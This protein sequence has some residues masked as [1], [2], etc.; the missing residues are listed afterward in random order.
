MTDLLFPALHRVGNNLSLFFRHRVA[1]AVGLIFAADSMLFGTWVTHIPFVKTRL[2]LN[3]AELG[4]ALF[5]M[6]LGLLVMNPLS[7]R[8]L[9]RIG[10]VETTVYT[11]ILLIL[12]FSLPV[13]MPDRWSLMAAL[14]LVGL[15]GALL[16]V[17][18]NT[19][20]TH[21]EQAEGIFIMSSCHGMW[22][23]GGMLGSGLSAGMIALS[24]SP[25]THLIGL[26]VSLV[27][28]VW[29]VVRP[30][31][32]RVP[33]DEDQQGGSTFV[34]PNR[35]LLLM[36]FIGLSISLAEGVAFDW[37]TVYMR[38]VLGA[39]EQVAALA[40]TFFA[41][42]MMGTRFTGDVLIP[43][44][45][46]RLLLIVSTLVAILAL[47]LLILAGGPLLGVVGFLLLG[48]GVALGAPILYNAAARIP[49][50]APGAGLA[51]YATFS[52]VGFLAGPP[53][54]GLIGEYFGLWVGFACVAGL[55]GFSVVALRVVRL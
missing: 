35:D 33:V 46:E 29:I 51:T 13:W 36:I 25:Y 30:V 49:G 17:A 14:F 11:T 12:A 22:S 21:I 2:G 41:M 32:G 50:L 47:L 28:F 16:N 55:L 1:L 53:V 54:I 3:D 7:A 27:A 9:H 18:M 10:L 20:A 8:L 23:L 34:S 45:G 42:T 6:P 5:G 52:F 37:S 26:A 38:D 39:P 48:A 15:C 24:V 4:L 40:F 19:C 44:F 31:L 43:H